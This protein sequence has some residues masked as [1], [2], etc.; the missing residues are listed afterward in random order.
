MKIFFGGSFDPVH[1][2]HLALALQ[3]A[4]EFKHKVSFMP[5]NGSPNYK[6]PPQASLNDR[7]A[8]LELLIAEHPQ[9][10]EIDYHEAQLPEYSPTFFSLTRLRR[11]YGDS[12]PFYFVI[13]GD[14]LINLSIWDYWQQLFG[15]TN[16]I[17]ARR[18]DYPLEIMSAELAAQVLPRITPFD[19]NKL[20]TSGKI[21]FSEF[22]PIDISSTLIRS[23]IKAALPV[24]ELVN[25]QV[26][27]YINDHNLYQGN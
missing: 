27:H 22:T 9:Q 8:M 21:H 18:P 10:L 7:L 25:H 3:I 5:L 1:N 16:F 13:G 2:G 23:R 4:N 20:T 12:E 26:S 24:T 19:G 15:L 6:A 14:S 17:V 11:I